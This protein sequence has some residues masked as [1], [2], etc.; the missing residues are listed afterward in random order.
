MR[1]LLT[2]TLLLVACTLPGFTRPKGAMGV[3]EGD[4]NV[5]IMADGREINVDCSQFDTYSGSQ[6]RLNKDS[7]QIT[8]VGSNDK[9]E[10]SMSLIMT[11]PAHDKGTFNI[12][13]SEVPT[14]SL[15]MTSTDYPTP[16]GNIFVTKSGSITIKNFPAVNGFCGGECTATCQFMD[17]DGKLGNPFQVQFKFHVKRLD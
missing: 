9:N 1:K 13:G 17:N 15:T 4:W 11:F 3:N 5:K 12:H 8:I 6:V 14:G 7:T 10:R 16:P 2:A